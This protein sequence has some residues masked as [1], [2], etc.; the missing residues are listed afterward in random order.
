M[1]SCSKR[2]EEV[3]AMGELLSFQHVALGIRI[4]SGISSLLLP[5]VEN[6]GILTHIL[7]YANLLTE[8]YHDSRA[9]LWSGGEPA[10]HCVIDLVW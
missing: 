6:L 9:I 7:E 8:L 3:A 1:N 4:F 5:K 10:T 2:R